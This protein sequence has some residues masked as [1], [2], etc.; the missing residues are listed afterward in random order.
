VTEKTDIFHE[1]NSNIAE[2]KPFVLATIVQT[3]GSSPR[4][5]G[6]RML[7]YPDGSIYGTIGGGKFEKLVIDD[8]VDLFKSDSTSEF[9][10]YKFTGEG[11]D[12]TGMSCGGEAR[13]LL[14]KFGKPKRLVIFGGGHVGRDL[15][16]VARGLDFSITVVDDRKEIL[17]Q[18]SAGIEKFLADPEYSSDIPE[19]DENCYVVIVTRGHNTDRNVL[20]KIIQR[21]CA[22]IGMIGS[23][24]KVAKVFGSLKKAGISEKKLSAVK[25][26]VGLDIGAEGP[27][28]I[29]V[30]IAAELVAAVKGKMTKS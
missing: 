2:G 15:V 14:E 22:Y 18:Y 26:P 17:E 8:S 6:A 27:Y 29:A 25:A 21:N 11:S 23:Q 13:V 28:E 7:V 1:I 19:L 4:Q 16:K 10:R 9:K 20:E 3:V 24:K 12:S 5:T 30:S